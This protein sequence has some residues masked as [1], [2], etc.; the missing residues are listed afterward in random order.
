MTDT[1][2]CGFAEYAFKA[3]VLPGLT[4]IAVRGK[5]SAVVVTEKKVV[6]KLVDGDSITNLYKI[7]D[8][9]GCVMTG[10]ARTCPDTCAAH[11]AVSSAPSIC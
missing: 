10:P 3:A 8:K 1:Y 6:D 2:L 7:T 9:I 11:H 4:S 5:D